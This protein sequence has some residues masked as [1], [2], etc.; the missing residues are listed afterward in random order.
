[1]NFV[2]A[3]HHKNRAAVAARLEAAPVRRVGHSQC[4]FHSDRVEG[5]REKVGMEGP[6]R[7]D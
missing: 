6:Y 4:S 1:M 3:H 7:H 2:G 5:V